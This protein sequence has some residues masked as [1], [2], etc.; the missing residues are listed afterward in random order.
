[1]EIT[2]DQKSRLKNGIILGFVSFLV[3]KLLHKVSNR[4]P[5]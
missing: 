4:I 3:V 2:D 5:A 1:M